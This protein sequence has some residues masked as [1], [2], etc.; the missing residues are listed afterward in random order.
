MKTETSFGKWLYNRRRALDLTRQALADQAGC[1]EI[2][3]RRIENN[4]LK[5][6]RELA[7]ILLEKLGI[8]EEARPHWIGFARGLTGN[9]EQP[10]APPLTRPPTNLPA[11]LTS[12]IGRKKEQADASGLVAKHRVVTLLG[13]GGIGKTSLALHL[14]HASLKDHPDGVWF[15]ALDALT[16]P[17]LVPQAVAAVFELREL[18]NRSSLE[19]LANK[20]REKTTLLILDNCEH[21]IT[22]CVQLITALLAACPGI[23]ILATSREI[24]NIAGEAVYPV[25]SLVTPNEKQSLEELTENEA[26]R[27]F[28]ERASLAL[29]SF[30]LTEE[31]AQTVVEICQ[32]VDGMPLAIELAAVCVNFLQVTEIL[33]QL[34]RSF[35]LL[36]S[37]RHV[38][39]SHHQT[40]GASLDWS[41]SLLS[42]DE[43]RV[44]RRLS[45][46]A[47]GWTL[48]SAQVVCDEEVLGLIRA[49]VKKSLIK[50][51]QA[52][53]RATRY[54]FHEMVRQYAHKKLLEAGEEATIRSRHLKYFLDFS[55]RAEPA[56]RGPQQG[57]WYDLIEEE[58][59]NIRAALEQSARADLEAGLYLSGRLAFY[60]YNFDLQEGLKWTTTFVQRPESKQYPHGRAKALLAQGNI[61][62]HLQQF[63]VARVAAEEC[64]ALFRACGDRNGEFEGLL[65]KGSIMQF[66]EGMA[67]K[68]D[69]HKQALALA[70]SLGD[71]WKKATALSDLA[72][73]QRDPQYSRA[74]WEEANAIFRQVGDWRNLAFNLAILGFTVLSNGE[75][76]AA[77]G[78]L[79]E[80]LEI[81]RRMNYKR[82]M[83]FVLTS[84][85]QIAL[86]RGDYEQAR[87]YLSEW[88]ALAEE[89]GNRMGYLWARARIG[90]VVLREGNHSE[91][92]RILVDVLENFHRDR[93]TSGLIFVAEKLASLAAMTKK[94]ELA[95]RLIG[96]SD[97][98]RS[99]IG[100]PRPRLEQA[101]LDHDI[102]RLRKKTSKRDWEEQYLAGRTMTLDETVA[103]ALHEYKKYEL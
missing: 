42:P 45:V 41:W 95:A 69:V 44:L 8:P 49:L 62:W 70:L 56:L 83:E 90:Y 65:I 32:R 37:D 26:V 63:E 39:M 78:I 31:N 21:V 71:P 38:T 3:L 13:M 51:E 96:W 97:A 93:N 7:L 9:P 19:M 52:A 92:A 27:L 74:A 15:V 61:L 29:P 79:D 50:V 76:E 77:Q 72:W 86:M 28:I 87:E 48:E 91:A 36:S 46:F 58:R 100:H 10:G 34:Q 20:L 64:L 84:K 67:Q 33:E 53:G 2:T 59:D 24:L 54:H 99:E 94:P 12:F 88:A 18:G 4:T 81:N 17:A 66:T 43:Q 22:G 102:A 6:S 82:E 73:D 89:L 101:D 16:D 35:A 14:G 1:A 68:T 25:P 57:E 11:L 40:L 30:R 98:T 23:T 60:W 5:P 47:G 103:L 55:E 80:C 75:M 85:G